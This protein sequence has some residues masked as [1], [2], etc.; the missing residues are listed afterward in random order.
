MN[1]WIVVC[2]YVANETTFYQ[3][4]LCI[5]SILREVPSK[6]Y[7]RLLVVDDHSTYNYS[8]FRSHYKNDARIEFL[9]LGDPLPSYYSK[10]GRG[11]EQGRLT[12]DGH[13]VSLHKG[14]I[15]AKEQG[16]DHIW[17]LDS[18]TLVLDG[19]CLAGASIVMRDRHP[20]VRS[21]GDYEWGRPGVRNRVCYK[22]HCLDNDDEE[23]QKCNS[24]EG[25]TNAVCALWSLKDYAFDYRHPKGDGTE[26]DAAQFENSGQASARLVEGLWYKGLATAYFPFFW[27]RYVM[28]FGYGSLLFTR[29]QVGE[30]G[31]GNAPETKQYGRR[32]S[33]SFYAGFLQ[34]KCSTLKF[35]KYLHRLY[36]G[37]AF[38]DVSAQFNKRLLVPPKRHR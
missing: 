32:R 16:A 9:V 20:D 5:E 30:R 18:D 10:T 29:E 6:D 37:R 23:Q 13:G 7:T 8:E 33:G 12:S 14:L 1:T 21:V 36:K 38:D 35:H 24:Y 2:T 34:L 22:D 11:S 15:H 28:H 4:R 31:L 3:L 26:L 17:S 25:R 27:H 19:S